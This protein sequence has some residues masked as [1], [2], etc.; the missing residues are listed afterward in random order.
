MVAGNGQTIEALKHALAAAKSQS[1]QRHRNVKLSGI[2]SQ[3]DDREV[4]VTAEQYLEYERVFGK[5]ERHPK[6]M[7]PTGDQLS[8]IVHLLDAGLPPYTDFSVCVWGPYGH[9]IE[10]KLKLQGVT[11]GRHGL[12]RT[13]ELQGPPKSTNWLSLFNVLLTALVMTRA[14]Y[15]GL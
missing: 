6:D 12:I 15:L 2:T 1:A 14:I 4:V 5:G 10:G 7:E 3:V 13:V 8:A 9:R 11:I